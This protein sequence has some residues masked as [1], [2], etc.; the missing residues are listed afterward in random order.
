MKQLKNVLEYVFRAFDQTCTLSVSVWY[1]YFGFHIQILPLPLYLIT[2]GRQVQG[3][4]ND[5]PTPHQ[6][7]NINWERL[8]NVVYAE[9]KWPINVTLNWITD[10]T[11]AI[12]KNCMENTSERHFRN[13]SFHT[14]DCRFQLPHLACR[15]MKFS[16]EKS[17]TTA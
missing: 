8:G 5:D 15:L 17:S 6:N 14:R 11:F 10:K 7:Q 9:K 4:A 16:S 2:L 13:Q 12:L 1:L 3:N